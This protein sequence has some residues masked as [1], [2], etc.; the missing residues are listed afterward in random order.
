MERYIDGFDDRAVR[1]RAKE[2]MQK[3]KRLK[4]DAIARYMNHFESKCA[5]SKARV[6]EAKSLI[7]NG[8]QH[9]LANNHPFPL[10]I[11][12]A[13]GAYL[14]DVDGNRYIDFLQA[15]GP[16]ILGHN[17]ASVR[18]K[19]IE[20][21][22]NEGPLTGLFSEHEYELAKLIHRH[23]PSVEMF[24]MLGSGTEADIL[25][26]RLARAYTGKKY[27]I[28]IKHNYHGWGDQM[29]YDADSIAEPG[30]CINGVLTEGLE[31]TQAVPP[32][33]AD[34]LES[35]IQKNADRG[36]TAA[37]ILE[38]VGQ[39]SGALPLTRAF[40]KKAREICD[41]YGVLMIYDEVVTGFRLG[42]GGAQ[43]FYGTK[44]DLTVLGKI[45]G[46]GYPSAGG[47]GGRKEIMRLLAAGLEKD[48]SKKVRVGGTLS[49]NP[50]TCVAGCVTIL[51][52][53]CRNAH[54]KLK[55]AAD[56]FV[57]SLTDL[58]AEYDVP[59]LIFNQHSILHIDVTA[60]QHIAAFYA[61][62]DDPACKAQISEATDATHEFSMALAA[63]G[64]I[65]AGGNKSY[66]S[67]ATIDVTDDALA[68]F[69][70]VFR[71]FQ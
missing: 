9:N 24:R 60:M 69:E 38:G 65:V 71:E 33:D 47:I 53:E 8:V 52:L 70:R 14:Y 23:F 57:R 40:H 49:A 56:A 68:A 2:V 55:I 37:F 62:Q 35:L 31:Y 5:T 43:E 11:R 45:I 66:M 6:E 61:S 51:E 17:D 58:A 67:L 64:V 18:E 10:A 42:M 16:I 28:R 1:A 54:T 20:L 36:G 19:A 15:G 50:L 48:R 13:E 39:D 59:A 21:I 63:E 34:A 30:V 27:I 22:R 12:K 41:K 44:A 29:I 32:N 46:G 7:V 26:F 3:R 25:A 4:P